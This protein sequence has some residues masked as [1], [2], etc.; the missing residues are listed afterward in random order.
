[1]MRTSDL[2][3]RAAYDRDGRPLGRIIDLL[4]KP[5]A[6]GY[7]VHAALVTPGREG[8][9]LGYSRP[10]FEGPWLIQRIVE[11]LHRGTREIAWADLRLDAGS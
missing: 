9:L 10:G 7:V 6:D 4:T 3:G 11:R 1:M 5:T 8:R 2:I